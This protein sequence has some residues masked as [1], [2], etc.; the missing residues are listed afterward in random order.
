MN[1]IKPSDDRKI[2]TEEGEGRTG[3]LPDGSSVNVR[4]WSSDG[5]PTIEIQRPNGRRIKY[6]Y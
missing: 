2:E 4:S 1:N 5:R 6:R 3:V